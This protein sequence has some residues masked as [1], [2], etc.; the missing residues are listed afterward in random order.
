MMWEARVCSPVVLLYHNHNHN[1]VKYRMSKHHEDSDTRAKD[2]FS[3]SRS[4]CWG[5]GTACEL[6]RDGVR[7]SDRVHG[8]GDFV[9]LLG[10]TQIPV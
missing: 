10:E 4:T 7:I 5:L 2:L 6:G 9:E 1:D 8:R 3:R